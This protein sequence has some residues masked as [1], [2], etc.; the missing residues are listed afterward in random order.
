LF[1]TDNKGKFLLHFAAERENLKTLQKLWN[2]ANMY[3][4]TEEKSNNF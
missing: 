1:A 2:H 4:T 3:L